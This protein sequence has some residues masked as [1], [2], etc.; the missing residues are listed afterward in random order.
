MLFGLLNLKERVIRSQK[1]LIGNNLSLMAK[2]KSF[3][4]SIV[5]FPI[6]A[7]SIHM[8]DYPRG[9]LQI[10]AWGMTVL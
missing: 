8:D 1:L 5:S 7:P 9:E 3:L 2:L 4:V 10:S 6:F